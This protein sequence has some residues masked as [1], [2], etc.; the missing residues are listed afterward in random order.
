MVSPCLMDGVLGV[1][2]PPVL[3]ELFGVEGLF[4]ACPGAW[5]PPGLCPI[6]G[7]LFEPLPPGFCP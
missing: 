3:A 7:L 2:A 6:L 5:A 1:V 4:A